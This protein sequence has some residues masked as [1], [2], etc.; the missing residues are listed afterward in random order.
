MLQLNI[1]Q[2]TCEIE[3]NESSEK[4]PETTLPLEEYLQAARLCMESYD[5][6]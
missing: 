2:N 5:P 4:K 1:T 6:I 3:V